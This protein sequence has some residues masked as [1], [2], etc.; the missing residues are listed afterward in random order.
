MINGL[1]KPVLKSLF[2]TLLIGES[3]TDSIGA[4]IKAMMTM[5]RN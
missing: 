5:M 1:K 2:L 3:I 4:L